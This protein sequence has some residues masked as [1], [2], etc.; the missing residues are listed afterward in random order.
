MISRGAGEQGSREAERQGGREA[1]GQ[2]GRGKKISFD[3][4]SWIIYGLE[5]ARINTVT[6]YNQ[7]YGYFSSIYRPFPSN[8]DIYLGFSCRKLS[9]LF[10]F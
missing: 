10:T 6:I 9:D 1:G 4:S 8:L 2:R 7:Q 3:S 5:F